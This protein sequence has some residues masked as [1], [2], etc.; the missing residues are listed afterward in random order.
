M[1]IMLSVIILA[2]PIAI[3]FGKLPDKLRHE[4]KQQFE[5]DKLTSLPNRQKLLEN[6]Y[7]NTH[8]V[9]MLI[10]M[11]NFKEVNNVYGFKNG[12]ELIKQIANRIEFL[13][14][15]YYGSGDILKLPKLYKMSADEFAIAI[16]ATN[17]KYEDLQKFCE[18]I[19]FGLESVDYEI[20][21]VKIDIKVTIGISNPNNIQSAA[22][23][24]LQADLAHKT[25]KENGQSWVI[26][27]ND[28][29]VVNQYKSNLHWIR[30]LK[31]AVEHDKIIPYFQPIYN[32]KTKKVDKYEA[33]IRL[34]DSHG[35]VAVPANF[36]DL[37]K[38][39]KLYHKISAI[40]NKKII[41]KLLASDAQISFNMN[42]DDFS[43]AEYIF[44]LLQL[45]KSYGIGHRLTIEIV[46]TDQIKDVDGLQNF[47]KLVHMF[48]CK[49]AIDDFGSGYSNFAHF[50]NSKVDF[51]KIDGSLIQNIL[52]DPNAQNTVATIIK[53]AKLLDIQ[54]V[55]EYV[56][57]KEIFEY[58]LGY[59]IDYFQGYYIGKPDSDLIDRAELEI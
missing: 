3:Y 9:I 30:E 26:Y 56:S 7:E 52:I 37:S 49:V 38:K 12:D 36:L 20:S 59:E 40:C 23:E 55:A 25:A 44:D 33:L 50:I 42:V 18:F 22:Q 43:N 54:V 53:L 28:L 41:D 2:T 11:D 10:N 15:E 45:V 14:N 27:D 46:E 8:F 19:H 32:V 29:K 39:V 1:L 6:L 35:N 48:G 51:V 31:Q 21:S 58:L 34:V 13:L 4:I 17:L 16:D 24:L 47:V 5:I 57:S